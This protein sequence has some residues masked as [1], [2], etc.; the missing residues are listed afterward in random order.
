MKIKLTS[1]YVDNQ[2]NALRFYADV[3]GFTKKAD[4]SNGPYRWLTVTSAEE[5]DGTELQLALNDNPAAKAYQEAIFQQGQP[6]VMFFTDDV[7][8]DYERI[9]AKGGAFTM[10]PTEVTGS[11]IA[12]L[13]DS[14]GNLVQI[15]QLARW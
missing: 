8:G 6:A 1:V 7:R 12:Q 4:F 14:C 3:L 2:E 11:T 10:P 9:K 13:N 15:T 5:P